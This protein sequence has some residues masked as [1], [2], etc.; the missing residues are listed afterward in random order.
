MRTTLSVDLPEFPPT[1]GIQRAE[2]IKSVLHNNI[3]TITTMTTLSLFTKQVRPGT[4]FVCEPFEGRKD[5]TLVTDI[6]HVCCYSSTPNHSCHNNI[7]SHRL[8]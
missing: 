3:M 1:S 8:I 2:V 7:T 6:V 5:K 4:G